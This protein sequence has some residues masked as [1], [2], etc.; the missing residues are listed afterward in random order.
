LQLEKEA[1]NNGTSPGQAHDIDIPPPRPKRKSNSLYPRKNGLSSETSTKE[2]SND[3][4]TKSNMRMSSANVETASHS[5]LQV[6]FLVAFLCQDFTNSSSVLLSILFIN[7]C[8]IQKL[9]RKEVS[10]KGS[11][12]EVLNLFREVPSASFSS[13]NKSSSNH[14]A[15]SGIEQAKTEIRDTT[16]LGKNSFSIDMHKDAKEIN[17]REMERLN[18]IHISSKSD[19]P[20]EGYL[21]TSTQEMKLKLMSVE[22]AYVGRQTAKTSHS[23]TEKNGATS[24]LVTGTDESH[25]DQTSDQEGVNG[26]MNPCIH[27]TLSVDPKF[28]INPTPLPC[29]HNYN[30]FPP[31]TQCNCNQDA[32]KSFI[33]MSST[34]SNMLVSTLLSN[35]AIHAAARLAASYWP[36]AESNSSVDPN[37][38]NPTVGVQGSNIDSPPSMASMVAAT[39]AAASAW[40]AT[41]GL[42]PFFAPPMAFP[43]VPAPSAAFP[44]ADVRAS[45]KGSDCQ[46]ENVQKEC[47]EAQNQ[48]QSQAVR[49]SAPSETDG[50]RKGEL[51]LQTELKISPVQNADTTP[52]AVADTSDAFRNK[53][54]QD[55]SSCGSNT[56]SSSDVEAGNVPEKQDK[57]NDNAKQASCS[58]SSDTNNRRFRSSGST[59]DS[60]KEVSEEV[61]NLL[62]S[63]KFASLNL[64]ASITAF[65]I[66]ISVVRVDLL[67]MHSSVEKSFPRAFL[68]RKE[69]NQMIFPRRKMK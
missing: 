15:L 47:Q 50:S 61:Y 51:S 10:E 40:W 62:T 31:M 52:T 44:T 26:R 36:A 45:E 29:P 42:L 69:K 2:V 8:C 59:S 66:H 20:H 46:V 19:H 58:N 65:L 9:Q 32:Y 57:V 49:V 21:D 28:N 39:V 7:L 25:P 56:P 5:S 23:V 12:S 35:P 67:L 38:E 16:T 24:V 14:G 1:M 53:K 64:L 6:S 4:S 48:D 22:T 34:F 37:Q 11:C 33:N 17:D 43:F 68:L 41:Q 13:V 55:R 27:P 3:K 54:K 18:G 63:C 60:W 30:A